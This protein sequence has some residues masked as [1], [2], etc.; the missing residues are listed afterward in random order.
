MAVYTIADTHFGHDNIVSIYAR[1]HFNSVEEHD[2]VIADNI[3]SR[4]CKRD[5]LYILGDVC[6]NMKSFHYVEEIAKAVENLYIVLGNHDFERSKGARLM[7]YI[8]LREHTN[9]Q[10]LGMKK[11][12]QS[13]LTHAPMHPSELKG[14]LNIHGHI[15]DI[16][17]DDERYVNVSC[18]CVDYK[19]INI[20][21]IFAKKDR[22]MLD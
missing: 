11:Y 19:P 2:A 7:D 5:T 12:K 9:L 13:W 21:D 3:L 22:E 10:L 15:H 18:E 16:A 20:E 6:L 14:R 8:A 4:C 17:L 1:Q